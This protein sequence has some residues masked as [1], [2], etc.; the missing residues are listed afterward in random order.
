M[1]FPFSLRCDC[2]ARCRKCPC[3]PSDMPA[4]L[5]ASFEGWGGYPAGYCSSCDELNGTFEMPA[6]EEFSSQAPVGDSYDFVAEYPPCGDV[7]N[8]PGVGCRWEAEW[9]FAC[10]PQACLECAADCGGS[11]TT[12]D[13]CT[14]EGCGQ[15]WSCGATTTACAGYG[16]ACVVECEQE[17]VCVFDEENDPRMSTDNVR[18]SAIACPTSPRRVV[19]RSCFGCVRCCTST[20]TCGPC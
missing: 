16:G 1:V 7:N 12:D 15:W 8:L 9:E 11:C 4:A 2:C 19:R 14:P 18:T 3:D 6:V 10:L 13:D 5:Q 17:T 20:S